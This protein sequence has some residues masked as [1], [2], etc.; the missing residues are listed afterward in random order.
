V[1][2]AT[3]LE[4]AGGVTAKLSA[5]WSRGAQGGYQLAAGEPNTGIRRDGVVGDAGMRYTGSSAIT[6][7]RDEP[8][9]P[10]SSPS[11]FF[12]AGWTTGLPP[13]RTTARTQAGDERQLAPAGPGQAQKYFDASKPP[14]R[15]ARDFWKKQSRQIG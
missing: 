7:V 8:L 13:T 11:I 1:D 4:F 6:G 9:A 14:P 3:R 12:F 5:Y 15:A 10:P 2:Q